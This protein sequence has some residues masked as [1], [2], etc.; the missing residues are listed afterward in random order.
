MRA[1]LA[2]ERHSVNM[3]IAKMTAVV[4]SSPVMGAACSKP[5][6]QPMLKECCSIQFLMISMTVD[7]LSVPS[8][9]SP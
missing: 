2:H 9:D 4:S 3:P 6:P 8:T 1:R 7:N 5:W